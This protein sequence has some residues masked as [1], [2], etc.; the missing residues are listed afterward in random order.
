MYTNTFSMISSCRQIRENWDVMDSPYLPKRCREL[1]IMYV[2]EC[3]LKVTTLSLPQQIGRSK[4]L[5][6]SP[7]FCMCTWS[8]KIPS[9]TSGILVN[10]PHA[11]SHITFHHERLLEHNS[12]LR[13]VATSKSIFQRFAV[14]GFIQYSLLT[15]IV[16][17]EW[18]TIMGTH[19]KWGCITY[20]NSTKSFK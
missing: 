18:F 17:N 4:R 19:R 15:L 14:K 2:R 13:W 16:C 12:S 7:T 3:F 5:Q 9:R 6:F 11:V 8:Q 10:L 1:F 20:L